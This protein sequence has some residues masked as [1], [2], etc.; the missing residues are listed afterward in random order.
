MT[1]PITEVHHEHVPERPHHCHGLKAGWCEVE[2]II[3]SEWILVSERVC[4]CECEHCQQ[5]SSGMIIER[6]RSVSCDGMN[7]GLRMG[8][9]T[10]E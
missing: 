2:N 9:G 1:H 8:R 6:H 3:W 7:V 5:N 4:R 10:G